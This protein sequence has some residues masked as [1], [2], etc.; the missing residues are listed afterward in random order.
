MPI[1]LCEAIEEGRISPGQNI[2]LVGFG[3]GLTW[4]AVVLKWSVAPAAGVSPTYRV[5]WRWLLYRWAGVRSR[6]RHTLHHL[7][8]VV[9]RLVDRRSNN[10]HHGS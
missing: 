10:N 7:L 5:W 9:I 8:V 1:A 4:A 6:S 3:A 2:V